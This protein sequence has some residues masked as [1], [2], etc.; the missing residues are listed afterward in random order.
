MQAGALAEWLEIS[1]HDVCVTHSAEEAI[2]ALQSHPPYDLLVTDIFASK[3]GN[4]EIERGITLIDKVRHSADERMKKMPIISISGV[5][6]PRSHAYTFDEPHTLGS[7]V[8][9]AKP[10]DLNRLSKTIDELLAMA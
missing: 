4:S 10:L 2:G 9:L 8:H 1:G 6:F 3:D 7:N 5:R